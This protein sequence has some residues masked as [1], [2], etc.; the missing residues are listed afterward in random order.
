MTRET[1]KAITKKNGLRCKTYGPLKGGLCLFHHPLQKE[2]FRRFA[3]KGGYS[4]LGKIKSMVGFKVKG[5]ADVKTLLESV[6]SATGA[7]ELR[8][9]ARDLASLSKIYIETIE[10]TD[11]EKR[12]RELEQNQLINAKG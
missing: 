3:Q 7:G 6:L 8:I 11:T 5:I 2:K 9:P 4:H 1:C 10:K 12:L